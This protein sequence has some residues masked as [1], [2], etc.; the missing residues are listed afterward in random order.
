MPLPFKLTRSNASV[1]SFHTTNVSEA[2]VYHLPTNLRDV[3]KNIHRSE[4]RDIP[5]PDADYHE[6]RYFL[7]QTLTYGPYEIAKQWPQWVLETVAA[8]TGTGAAFRALRTEDIHR[9]CPLNAGHAELDISVKVARSPP[10]ECRSQIGAVIAKTVSRLKS[11]ASNEKGS[12]PDTVREGWEYAQARQRS[13]YAYHYGDINSINSSNPN[14]AFQ[15]Y[16]T[17]PRSPSAMS[18]Q[19]YS[20]PMTVQPNYLMTNPGMQMPM[21]SPPSHYAPSNSCGSMYAQPST[22]SGRPYQ[23]SDT[24][25][26]SS[27]ER[28]TSTAKTTPPGS[29]EDYVEQQRGLDRSQ[30]KSSGPSPQIQRLRIAT[31]RCSSPQRYRKVN[32]NEIMPRI[33]SISA[34]AQGRSEDPMVP[35]GCPSV[36]LTAE[37]LQ[38]KNSSA[39]AQSLRSSRS[40]H[41]ISQ[42]GDG[43]AGGG[44]LFMNANP[45]VI[46]LPCFGGPPTTMHQGHLRPA[47]SLFMERSPLD[48]PLMHNS[49]APSFMD[50]G[51]FHRQQSASPIHTFNTQAHALMQR[52][53]P[54]TPSFRHRSGLSHISSGYG[55]NIA[56][57]REANASPAPSMRSFRTRPAPP[58]IPSEFSVRRRTE[59]PVL[60]SFTG[61]SRSAGNASLDNLALNQGEYLTFRHGRGDYAERR[62]IA[63]REMERM[64]AMVPSNLRGEGTDPIGPT[65]RIAGPD[66]TPL[67]TLVEQIAEVEALSGK[68]QRGLERGGWWR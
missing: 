28:S 15:Q 31:S 41:T 53:T 60:S 45:S 16:A 9:L 4:P 39:H 13:K 46:S 51:D 54:S 12:R 19:T 7:Y 27:G 25:P 40:H 17:V 61:P 66:G 38:A 21:T 1:R 32:Q 48:V 3:E 36:P 62:E 33:R 55:S 23:R 2:C 5:L 10:P 11:K 35:P 49:A 29:E 42:H 26:T 22:I 18:H 6:V 24:T 30:S 56:G 20:Y 52:Q 43:S 50:P 37:N 44:A 67:P 58:P 64:H 47:S 14:L 68:K 34:M 63:R 65:M 57:P 59:I 8:W